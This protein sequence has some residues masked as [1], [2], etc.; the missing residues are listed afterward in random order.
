MFKKMSYNPKVHA[1]TVQ[2]AWTELKCANTQYCETKYYLS[3]S[4]AWHAAMTALIPID[5]SP[6]PFT[7]EELYHYS[8]I[9]AIKSL[10]F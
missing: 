5:T 2:L 4:E 3:L 10:V 9:S 7:H 1:H 6:E 8:G